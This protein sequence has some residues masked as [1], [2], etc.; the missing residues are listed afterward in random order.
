MRREQRDQ[1]ETISSL[2][3]EAGGRLV[4]VWQ[5]R[6]IRLQIEVAGQRRSLTMPN[7]PGDHRSMRNNS[8]QA[9]RLIAEMLRNSPVASRDARAM[10]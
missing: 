3:K 4:D 6:H 8:A 5:G 10:T 2:A 7:T 9:K 1:V